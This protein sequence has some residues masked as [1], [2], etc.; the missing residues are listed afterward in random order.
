MILKSILNY[1][2]ILHFEQTKVSD[3]QKTTSSNLVTLLLCDYS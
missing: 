3:V 2:I 1:K